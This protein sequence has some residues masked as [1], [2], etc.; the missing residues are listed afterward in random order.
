MLAAG[1]IA[2]SEVQPTQSAVGDPTGTN[3]PPT[4][5]TVSMSGTPAT[6]VVAGT[7]Y[8][9]QP[10]ASD[11]L[12]TALT[13]SIENPPAW[14]S[15]NTTNGS[16]TGTPIGAQVGT[17]SNITI[18]ASDGTQSATLAAF[19]ITVTRGGGTGS[20]TLT[21]VA[22]TTNTNGTPLTNL[23]G[24]YVLYGT[25]AGD[26][27]QTIALPNPAATSYVV[28]GLTTGT[29]FFAVEAYDSVGN[30]S[31]RSNIGSKTF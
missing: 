29:W 12:G 26:L 16:L 11:S 18:S 14:A 22:P 6:T 4:D 10:T 8:S 21:W 25:N 13:F 30:T 1:L 27:A 24:Y 2:C 15:F 20:A 31:A 3:P 5:D 23:A 9:F 19:A 17:Y 28:G 7:A